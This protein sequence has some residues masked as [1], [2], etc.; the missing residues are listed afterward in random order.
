MSIG[1]NYRGNNNNNNHYHD[2]SISYRQHDID[3]IKY[4]R[5]HY[6]CRLH[7]TAYSKIIIIIHNRIHF[8]LNL[9]NFDIVWKINRCTKEE[10]KRGRGGTELLSNTMESFYTYIHIKFILSDTFRLIV[11]SI[12]RK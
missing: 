2:D 6:R 8:Q 5:Q 12:R 4:H 3:I 7:R 10:R 9:L 11:R 1:G